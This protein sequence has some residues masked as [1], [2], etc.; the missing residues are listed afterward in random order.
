MGKRIWLLDAGH[1]GIDVN[2]IYTTDP[3]FDPSTPGAG[4]K[5][6]AHSDGTF[7]REG[8]FNRAVRA[9]IIDLLVQE[10]NMSWK[11][12][13]NGSKDTSLRDRVNF[14][15]QMQRQHGNCVYISIHG[16]AGGGT[17]F[18][19]YTSTGETESDKIAGVWIDEMNKE[20]PEKV[21]RGEKDRDFYVLK[22]TICPAILTESYFMD[23]LEDA[24][25][26]LSEEG[27][28]K[29]ALAHFNMMKKVDA[30]EHMV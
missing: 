3:S 14:A 1:G 18:E 10:P 13:N 24:K 4:K 19:V 22:N 9:E 17:G 26:M 16:N 30:G 7:I 8:A 27:Q 25:I 23:T 21:D 28:K 29:V 15:N 5:C 20:F 11:S 6:Y 12:I 2:G